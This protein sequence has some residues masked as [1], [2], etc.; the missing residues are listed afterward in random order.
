MSNSTEKGLE[1]LTSVIAVSRETQSKFEQ[2]VKLLEQWQPR[3]NLVAPSTM[4][5]IWIRH[6]ADSA[7][8]FCL[9]REAR[10]WIDIGSGAGFPG[11]ITA[12][13]LADSGGGRVELI[14]SSGKKCAFMNAVIRETGMR[15]MGVDVTVHNERIEKCLPQ[16]EVCDAVSARALASLHELLTMTASRL[17]DDCV[18]VFAKGR[19]HQREIELAETD[20]RFDYD[21]YDSRFGDGS[22]LVTVRNVSKKL[23]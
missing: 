12:L 14:E 9:H 23:K 10:R 1:E 4:S 13:L 11:L 8:T 20:W 5:E 19:E 6:V 7:Q 15:S 22:C 2:Y 3:I 18:G 16:L 17:E 21:V